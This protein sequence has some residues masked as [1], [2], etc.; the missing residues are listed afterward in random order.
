MKKTYFLFW[1][2][3]SVLGCDSSTDTQNTGGGGSGGVS[4]SGGSG[5]A[6]GGTGG[7]VTAGSG[8]VPTGGGGQGGTNFGPPP[9]NALWYNGAALPLYPVTDPTAGTR[10][11]AFLPI[12]QELRAHREDMSVWWSKEVGDGSL[13]GGFDFNADGVPDVGLV[14][15]QDTGTPCG[16]DTILLTGI[17]VVNGRTGDVYPLVNPEPSICWD[18]SGTVYP[19]H[20]WSGLGVMFGAGSSVLAT[21][22]YYATSGNF[23]QWNGSG[24]T[25]LGT[26]QFPST[27]AFDNVYT[28]DKPNAYGQGQSYVLYSHAANG[29]ILEQGGSDRFAFFTSSRASAYAVGPQAANQLTMDIPYLTGNRT[30]IAGRNYG[31]VAV[32]PGDSNL[33]TLIAGTSADTVYNDMLTGTLAADPWGQIER[34]VSIVDLSTHTVDDRFFSYAHD[35]N[36]GYKYEGRVV[37]PNGAFVRQQTGPS[38]L[39]FNVYEGGHWMLHVTQPGSTQDAVVFKDLFLWDIRDLDQDGTDEWVLSPSRD[40]NEPDV[41]GYYFVKWRT[42]IAHWSDATLSYVESFTIQSS[43]PTMVPTFRTPDLTTSR[44]F[45]YPT[46]TVRNEV[47]L[48]L[49]MTSSSQTPV[50]FPITPVP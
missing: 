15:T 39:A 16:A 13:F 40:P 26:F 12:A 46:L 32:D 7:V 17:D 50:I 21:S 37:Y 9:G 10:A 2:L 44:S 30:D 45:L 38:R 42:L 3:L 11:V 34:H 27:S 43:I 33:L 25:N 36:D 31:R 49:I 18:F 35:A 6:V 29:M 5:G 28:A 23:W 47:G 14:R 24:F 1:A 41:P 19:T 48:N 8:G 22:A 20:Q 4:T